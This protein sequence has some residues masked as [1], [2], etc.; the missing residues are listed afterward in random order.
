MWHFLEPAAGREPYPEM[1]G[2]MMVRMRSGE[3]EKG[4]G[5]VWEP[6]RRN[7]VSPGLGW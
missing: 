2:E 3:R 5:D 7:R 6:Q 4:G 1:A